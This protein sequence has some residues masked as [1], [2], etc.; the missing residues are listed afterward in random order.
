MIHNGYQA[1]GR[2]GHANGR[3]NGRT[4]PSAF[5]LDRL[6]PSNLEAERS[7]LGSCLI[8]CRM[9]DE[10]LAIG[11]QHDDF[12]R[13]V[14]GEIWL[15]MLAL[16]QSGDV[17]DAVTLA[18]HLE[19]HGQFDKL[20]GDELLDELIQSV[21][22]AANAV[23][24]AQ[25]VR[26][27]AVGRQLIEACTEIIREC[28]SNQ[29]T[30]SDLVCAAQERILGLSNRDAGG[31][32]ISYAALMDE[33][34]VRMRL[35]QDDGVLGMSCGFPDIDDMTCGF[36]PGEL[37]ILAARPG[38]G[39][40]SLALDFGEN[41][42]RSGQSV[43]FFSIEMGRESLGDR[44]I[45]GEANVDSDRFRKA[46]LL[47]ETEK[48]RLF[49]A[50]LGLSKLPIQIDFA[51]S[52]TIA[53]IAAAAR[54]H[55][56]RHGLGLLIVDYVQLIKGKREDNDNREQIVA[57]ISRNL[58]ALARSMSIPVLALAQLNREVEKR[59]DKTP[60]L[61]DLRES[62]SIEQDADVV[63]LL[64][65]PEYYN[66]NDKPGVAEVIVAKNRNGRTGMVPLAF[67]SH[68]TRFDSLTNRQEVAD[69]PSF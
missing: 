3:T 69:A 43:L 17:V 28:Y 11:L 18:D 21:P 19:H 68:C 6:P 39:K 61:S 22:H 1:N 38:M 66:E 53:E 67:V 29:Y 25:I 40:T 37:S 30:A 65:R 64:Y 35:R 33:V 57:D 55:H 50:A 20:G 56:R 42:S 23:Y 48:R 62:G 59:A 47:Q 45:T 51:P 46:W 7:V 44:V 32:T 36:R 52:R 26:E 14:H 2:N 49:Q 8:D 60:M 24:Y 15:A 9:I 31:E 27:K 41:V 58:K 16:H 10:V 13:A 54:R 5:G 12:F 34:M 4:L 63:F